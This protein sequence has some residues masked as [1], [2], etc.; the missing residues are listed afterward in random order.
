[1]VRGVQRA[2]RARIDLTRVSLRNLS[3]ALTAA[4]VLEAMTLS[5]A[6]EGA[7]G[8]YCRPFAS[9]TSQ[10]LVTYAWMKA[11][12]FC[13][14]E[15]EDPVVPE[16]AQGA[17]AIVFPGLQSL[18]TARPVPPGSV[19][20]TDRISEPVAAA[21]DPA[22]APALSKPK[23]TPAVA[24]G[25]SGFAKGTADWNAYCKRYWPASFDVKTG[26]VIK[27]RH[28]RVPCPG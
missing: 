18:P 17:A 23:A 19:P 24:V 5:I 4:L 3:T 16:T 22:A 1:M 7:S 14:N 15:D 10:L 9:E 8:D 27:V 20:A 25:K 21:V 12:T 2:R 6:A 28:K 26:T 11:Y 13:L